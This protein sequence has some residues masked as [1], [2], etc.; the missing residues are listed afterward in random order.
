MKIKFGTDG[1]RAVIAKDYT[2][3]NV[4]IV[5]QAT[6]R[7]IKNEKITSNG[8]IIGYD[9]RFMG[10]QFAEHCACVFAAMEIPVRIADCITPTPSVSWAALEYDAVGI[11]ITAS[12]NPPDY[13]GFKIKAPFGGPA[14]PAQIASVEDELDNFDSSLKVESYQTYLK[15]GRI[16]EIPLREQFKDVLSERL[17]LD[18]IR[19]KGIK[20]AHDCMF[21]AGQGMIK[22]LL[23]DQIL[24]LHSDFNPGFHGQAPE[25]I[26]KNLGELSKFIVENRCAVGIA[27]D[28]DADRVGMFDETGR[29]VD[30]H[31]V[32][33]LLTKYLSQEKGMKGSIIKTFSTTSMLDKQAEKYGLDIETT[34]IGFKYVAEKIVDGDVLVGGEESGGLAVKGHIPERDGIFIG[35]LITEMM[36]KEGK[37]LSE[38]VQDLVDEFGPHFHYRNDMHT[39]NDKKNAMMAYC[40][41]K[42]LTEINGKKVEKWEFTDGVKH[43]LNDGSWLLVRPSGTEPVLRIYSESSNEDEAQ[44]LVE[45]ASNVTNNM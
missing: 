15:Q 7:W 19:S 44:K 12:H 33:S 22:E 8:V 25:P 2:Y 34:P 39:S 21:G 16:R 29:F 36:V 26:E 9:G 31:E 1:W 35:L 45:Y 32:L 20:I 43:W 13:N 14:T 3:D 27:N 6:G 11:V 5:T 41:D 30:S 17:D 4:S 18:A 42:K 23:G 10:R 28:G 24:E 38:L 40:K 37:A